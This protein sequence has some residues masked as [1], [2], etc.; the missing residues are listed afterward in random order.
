[1]IQDDEK[2]GF[3]I[4][5]LFGC[6]FWDILGRSLV[7]LYLQESYVGNI[8]RN[9]EWFCVCGSVFGHDQCIVPVSAVLSALARNELIFDEDDVYVADGHGYEEGQA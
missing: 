2:R 7:I 8:R 1:M 6:L 3:F 5:F 4:K 9:S